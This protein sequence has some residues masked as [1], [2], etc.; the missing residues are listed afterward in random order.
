MREMSIE[1]IRLSLMNYQRVVILR[2]RDA[3]RYLPIWI[4][5]AEAEAIAKARGY[6]KMAIISGIGVREY[7]RKLGY[8]LEETYLVK[9]LL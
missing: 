6:S 9:D 7:Y 4:G 1:S 8:R 2:E 5:P 3:D